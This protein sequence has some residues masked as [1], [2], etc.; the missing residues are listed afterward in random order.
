MLPIRLGMVNADGPQDLYIY[1]LTRQGRV[2]STNY[3]TVKLPT[4]MDLPV[5]IKETFGDFYRDMF[6]QQVQQEQR[7]A[8]FLEYAWDM[9][10]CDPCAANPLSADELQ[11]L[12]VF[13]LPEASASRQA[14]QEVFLSRL[15]VRY[16]ADN[17]PEDLLF[18]ETADRA[19]FQGRYVI[20]HPWN[21]SDTCQAAQQYRADLP[22]RQAQEARTLASL[23]GWSLEAI[24]Q[25]LPPQAAVPEAPQKWWRQLWKN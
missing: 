3:R 9:N 19:N 13:W 7:R 8:V 6:T 2:E 15:H 24:R 22:Q 20:R 23:T 21:G 1:A 18:Q 12:G 10:W 11:R 17:F 25:K 14:A 16:D 4:G 5:F